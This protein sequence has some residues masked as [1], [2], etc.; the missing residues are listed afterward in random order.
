MSFTSF[1][2]FKGEFNTPI[3]RR[4]YF[5]FCVTKC[6]N[7]DRIVGYNIKVHIDSQYQYRPI[8]GCLCFHISSDYIFSLLYRQ[9][10][11]NINR[12]CIFL[13]PSACSFTLP[14]GDSRWGSPMCLPAF[15]AFPAKHPFHGLKHLGFNHVLIL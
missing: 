2:Q 5:P 12:G 15:R 8:K 10:F 14:L 11:I 9:F 7:T 1:Q 6:V 13:L 3:T 4:E